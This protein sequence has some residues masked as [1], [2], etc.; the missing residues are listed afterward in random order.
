[1]AHIAILHRATDT[2][3]FEN[4]CRSLAAA[5]LDVHFLVGA[6]ECSERDGVRFRPLAERWERPPLRRQWRR[7][8]RAWSQAWRLGAGI[9]HLH[10][11]H[12][13]PLGLALKLRGARV[14]YDVHE[15]Y[16][17][18][19][20][21]KLAGRP[22]RAG[23]KS[24]LWEAMEAVARRTLDGFVCA[25]ED[26][27]R[28]FP[29]DRVTVVHNYPRAD[30]H[31]AAAIPYAERPPTVLFVG[32]QRRVRGFWE[33]VRAM[34]VL[35][36]GLDCRL[37]LVGR[38]DPP[39]LLDEA[40]SHPGWRRVEYVPW[41][42]RESLLRELGRARIGLAALH[43]VPN[44]MSCLR[45]RKLFEYM[46]SGLP[47]IVPDVP[48]WRGVVDDARCGLAVDPLDPHAIAKAIE[49][50]LGHPDEAEEMGRRGRNAVSTR[51][52]LDAEFGGLLSLYR[53]LGSASAAA[54][55]RP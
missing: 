13:I 27:A 22:L 5:G 17:S 16:P 14:V 26:I 31:R 54:V 32:L 6:P 47:V 36:E 42:P 10:E 25:G 53:T 29:S 55:S 7:Q 37:R 24:G 8:Y 51:F 45:S 43:P 28:R 1:V 15:D 33:A 3:I 11:P 46:A 4:Q 19:A 52:N 48:G 34:D 21:S 44:Q 9:Y 35:P 12:L 18:H 23:F 20:R 30:E 40:A 38:A 41:Q 50:L 39:E 49:Y 2:R